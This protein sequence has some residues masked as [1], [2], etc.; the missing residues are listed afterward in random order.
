VVLGVDW[1]V[2][3]FT[4][5]MVFA[6]KNKE[7]SAM[8][9]AA[10]MGVTTQPVRGKRAPAAMGMTIR[11]YMKAMVRFCL[12]FRMVSFESLM[13]LGR[14]FKVCPFRMRS[15]KQHFFCKNPNSQFSYQ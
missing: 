8:A 5:R 2:F 14:L 15:I 10:A 13:A 9:P 11:L 6:T 1:W 3:C 7:D 12:M 4:N